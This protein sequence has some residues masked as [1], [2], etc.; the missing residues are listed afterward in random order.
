[1]GWI[2]RID[3]KLVQINTFTR[4]G[5][6]VMLVYG[7]GFKIEKGSREEREAYAIGMSYVDIDEV[8]VITK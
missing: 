6:K 3:D 2:E 5:K 4:N 8:E 7:I 1:M